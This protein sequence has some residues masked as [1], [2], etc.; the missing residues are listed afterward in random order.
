MR[1]SHSDPKK[2]GRG[3]H[4][5]AEGDESTAFGGD[6]GKSNGMPGGRGGNARA[7]LLG[8][9]VIGGMGGRGGVEEGMPGMDISDVGL[10]GG[11]SLHM[12]GGMGGESSQRDGRGGRGGLSAGAERLQALLGQNPRPHMSRP[13]WADGLIEYGRGGDGMDTPQYQARRLIIE[14]IKAEH[15]R[16]PAYFTT[17]VW[18]QRDEVDISKI[19]DALGSMRVGWRVS[20]EDHEYVMHDLRDAD[21]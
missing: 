13:Y 7:T 16:A 6:A 2:G 8:S 15:L 21:A 4:A 12:V 3:G 18:Y 11:F 1:H 14:M 17:E 10:S 20:I 9:T 5:I 19:N